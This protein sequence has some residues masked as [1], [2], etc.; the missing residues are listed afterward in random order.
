MNGRGSKRKG[1]NWERKLVLLFREVMPG[2]DVRR[3][4]QYRGGQEVAD[5]D[6]APFWV[7]AKRG[8]KP[9]IRAALR[10][11]INQAPP[12]RIPLAVIRDDRAAPIVALE[13]EDFLDLISEWWAGR[14]Q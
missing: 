4:L 9:N 14:T 3:G 7:E 13:L 10:Q 6:A 2:G 5:V 1:A 11:V 12:G 8:R